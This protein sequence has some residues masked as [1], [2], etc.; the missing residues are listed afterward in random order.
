[1]RCHRVS[2]LL[3]SNSIQDANIVLEDRGQGLN[4]CVCDV[5]HLVLN[6]SELADITGIKGAIEVYEEEMIPRGYDEVQL[7]LKNALMVHDWEKLMESPVVT[8]GTL[9]NS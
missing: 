4:H 1:M 8:R 6:L 3:S 2:G 7:S 9:K 5:K